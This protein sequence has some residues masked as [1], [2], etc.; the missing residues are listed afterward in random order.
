[1]D[2][3]LRK[4]SRTELGLYKSCCFCV[5]LCIEFIWK[6]KLWSYYEANLINTR[7]FFLTEEGPII[8]TSVI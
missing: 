8:Y 4:K 3:Q 2:F 6:E 7:I 5:I 1:M